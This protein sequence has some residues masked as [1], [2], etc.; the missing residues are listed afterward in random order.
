MYIAIVGAILTIIKIV[1]GPTISIDMRNKLIVGSVMKQGIQQLL[2]N[3]VNM[4][5]VLDVV[6]VAAVCPV[7]L[8]N[9]QLVCFSCL[10]RLWD[11]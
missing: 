8:Q 7:S 9:Q 1:T 2:V 4:F 5:S 6:I 10:F 11:L 3:M